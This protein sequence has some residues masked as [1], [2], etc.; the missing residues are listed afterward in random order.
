MLS[1]AFR[2][3]CALLCLISAAACATAERE[4]VET[5][6]ETVEA[7]DDVSTTGLPPGCGAFKQPCCEG[8]ICNT[9][10]ECDPTSKRCLY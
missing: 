2:L 6:T 3:T 8:Y 10:L 4:D 5:E 1:R 7:A 9:N